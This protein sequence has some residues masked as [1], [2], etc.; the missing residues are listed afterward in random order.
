MTA[1]S[2]GSGEEERKPTLN[3]EG[4]GT[5]NG[6]SEKQR[7]LRQAMATAESNRVSTA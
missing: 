7:L 1:K 2:K 6:N 4:S 5:R 3:T